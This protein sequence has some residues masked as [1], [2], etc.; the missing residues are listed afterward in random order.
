MK[1]LLGHLPVP[2][3]RLR[4]AGIDPALAPLQVRQAVGYMPE[5]ELNFTGI[6][7]LALTAFCG[8]LSGLKR[9]DAIG[10]AHEVLYYVGLAEERYREVEGYS[11]GMRQRLKLACALVHGPKMLL[12]D[13]P[14]TGLDPSGRKQM[15]EL[16]DDLAHTHHMD[17]LLCSHILHD[18]EQTCDQIMVLHQGRI[19]FCGTKGDFQKEQARRYQIRVKHD[20]EKFAEALRQAGCEVAETLAQ[21]Y[22]EITL[23]LEHGPDLLW[24]VARQEQLQLRHLAPATM[25]MEQALEKVL[26]QNDLHRPSRPSPP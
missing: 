23:P 2:A 1:S 26:D 7:G 13:E 3:G 24:K 15:L 6:S 9:K 4:L 22:L 20:A 25:T 14:T 11:T 12:L 5:E 16:I 19:L 10:R 17:V 8:E 21:R 18:I